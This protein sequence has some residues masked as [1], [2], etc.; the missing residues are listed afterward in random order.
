MSVST[1]PGWT[2][3]TKRSGFSAETY[4]SSFIWAILEQT[5]AEVPMAMGLDAGTVIML[6]LTPMIEA[7]LFRKGRKARVVTIAPLTLV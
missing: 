4:S 6:A 3:T 2:E 5:Y 7:S 1:A